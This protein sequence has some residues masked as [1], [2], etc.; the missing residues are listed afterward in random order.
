MTG[1]PRRLALL[2]GAVC[3]VAVGSA[4]TAATAG[5]GGA[6]DGPEVDVSVETTDL[7]TDETFDVTV[8]FR[9]TLD[10]RHAV[11]EVALTDGT[12]T[13]VD[14]ERFTNAE[15]AR[16][17]SQTVVFEDVSLDD[18]G[19]YDLTA[20]VTLR[21]EFDAAVGESEVT[22]DVTRP[23]PI[24][25]VSTDGDGAANRT[26]TVG[27]S[28]PREEP[29]RG[30]E[31]S[32]SPGDDAGFTIIDGEDTVPL[33]EGSETREVAFAVQGAP[34]GTYELPLAL[35]FETADGSYW[36]RTRTITA[37][38][39][40]SATPELANVSVSSHP[41]G[42]VV[43]GSVFTPED[44]AIRNVQVEPADAT[45]VGPARPAPR[46]FI[47]SLPGSGAEQFELTAALAGD[48]DRVPLRIEYL[49]AGVPQNTTVTVPYGGPRD[50]DP[51]Q[52][53][54]VDVGGTSLTA[55]VANTGD[56]NVA[57]VTVAVADADG[58]TR[59]D[60]F[61]VG[62]IE[63]GRFQPIGGGGLS[64][65]LAESRETVP[66]EI[67]YTLDGT[68]YTTTAEVDARSTAPTGGTDDAGTGGDGATGDTG[69]STPE[70]DPGAGD[71][72]G[73]GGLPV[74]GD[75]SILAVVGVVAVLA[76]ALV[77]G[78]VYRRR[79]D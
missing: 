51:V 7:W 65:R 25:D 63:P 73:D 52:L 12:G 59:T 40:E 24:V 3:L 77:G 60:E 48:R 57:G 28:N 66:V 44:K 64:F 79:P 47:S 17:E 50:E 74:V 5:A 2:V 11:E 39:S 15:L 58:V 32:L 6:D 49:S 1:R 10:S 18:P 31:L 4:L 30:V 43:E 55:D 13:L 61:F 67:S 46:A 70:F 34:A 9:N 14:R 78:V 23:G 21:D 22:V 37:A 56:S 8:S 41:N 68:Q 76:I 20:T 36:E 42:V 75:V 45:G 16:G 27:L 33:I 38:F 35:Q 54:G 26:V 53:T 62:S 69:A 71:D 72:G 29:I 19:L